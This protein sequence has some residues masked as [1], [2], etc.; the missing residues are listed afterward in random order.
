MVCFLHVMTFV[1]LERGPPAH[2]FIR[3]DGKGW[4]RQLQ[5]PPTPTQAQALVGCSGP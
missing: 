1:A 4:R 2:F 5:R 3:K